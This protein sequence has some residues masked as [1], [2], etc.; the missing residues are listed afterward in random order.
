MQYYIIK[1]HVRNSCNIGMSASPD[2]H[3]WSA[4]SSCI[5]FTALPIYKNNLK[6]MNIKRE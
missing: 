4:D 3:A 2:M 1:L 6:I 5:L